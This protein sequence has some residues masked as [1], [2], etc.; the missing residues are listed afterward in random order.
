[1]LFSL[2]IDVGGRQHFGSAGDFAHILQCL[3]VG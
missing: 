3:R 2:Q 1:M